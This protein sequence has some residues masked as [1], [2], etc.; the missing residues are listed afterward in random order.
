MY[1]FIFF[2]SFLAASASVDVEFSGDLRVEA[3]E[4][5][6]FQRCLNNDKTCPLLTEHSKRGEKE[7]S[8]HSEL[9]NYYSS[10]SS[11]PESFDWGAKG[12]LTYDLNQHIP[13]YCGSCWA[14]AVVSM[15]GDRVKIQNAANGTISRRDRVPSVQV[16]LNCG[17]AG[18]C[19]GGDSYLAMRWIHENTI[20]DYTCQ[21]YTATDGTCDSPMDTCMT[22]DPD[23][24]I[25]CYAIDKGHYP[26][27]TL[28]E[29]GRVFG[30]EAIQ[31]EIMERGPVATVINAACIETYTGGVSMYDVQTDS[32]GNNAEPCQTYHFNH[33]IQLNGWG[34]DEK[35]TE[36][37]IG[38]NSWGT[39]WGEEG[40]FKIVRGGAYNPI[41]AYWGVPGTA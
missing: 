9:L 14:H 40:F 23:A 28:G 3:N 1:T 36:Y 6:L 41:G 11:L 25:G 5:T 7:F 15:I 33:A 32:M 19:G 8:T 2:L 24:S 17:N 31:R 22:C 21:Q 16:L 35:G 34:V 4:K 20:P 39:Y 10:S 26:V 27:F 18:S 12:L 37:W 13:T 29:Y 38:R 30:E